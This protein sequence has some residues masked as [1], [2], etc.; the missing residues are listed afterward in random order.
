M[1]L[2]QQSIAL[3]LLTDDYSVQYSFVTVIMHHQCH[4]TTSELP[5]VGVVV[6]ML[7]AAT[8]FRLQKHFPRASLWH[9]Q[10]HYSSF[11]LLS[12]FMDLSR[13]KFTSVHFRPCSSEIASNLCGRYHYTQSIKISLVPEKL[14]DSGSS[15][16]ATLLRNWWQVSNQSSFYGVRL[17]S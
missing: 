5:T 8:D 12:F 9:P 17:L 15:N 14:L 10:S 13:K 7:Q 1:Y 2:I 3:S 11:A 6:V 16:V 4:W